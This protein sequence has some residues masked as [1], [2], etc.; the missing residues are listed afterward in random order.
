MVSAQALVEESS[1]PRATVLL[2]GKSLGLAPVPVPVPEQVLALVG[3]QGW[4]LGFEFRL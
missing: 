4:A 2:P 3:A 1:L